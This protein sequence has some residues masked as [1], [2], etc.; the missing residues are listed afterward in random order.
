MTV[1]QYQSKLDNAVT[2][3]TSLTQ[4]LSCVRI[5]V[6][7]IIRV[8]KTKVCVMY[9]SNNV[10]YSGFYHL[11]NFCDKYKLNRIDKMEC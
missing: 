8:R 10:F 9:E 3:L 6:Y 5:V 1:M 4:I 2:K 11:V 7:S